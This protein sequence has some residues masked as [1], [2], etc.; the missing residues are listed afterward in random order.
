MNCVPPV[1]G[2]LTALREV[3]TESGA[4]LIFDEVMTGFRVAL[5]GAQAHYDIQPDLTTLGK[6]IGGGMPVG[7]FGGKAEIMQQLAPVG[8]V[9]QAG[10]LSGNPIAMTAGLATLDLISQEGFYSPIFA[11]TAALT[12]GLQKLADQYGIGF[13]SNHVG[14]MFGFFFNDGEKVT[15]YQQV[16]SCNSE[17]FN[18]F[19][20]AMLS[21]GVYLAPASY[22]A[23]FVSACHNTEII[24]QTLAIADKCFAQL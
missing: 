14:T 18:K 2:F 19:F 6:V 9:Y 16:M 20:H 22:E 1:D 12:S 3:C 21:H 4:V 23:G 10:T 5:G 7:A 24:D 17:R 15:G 8:P 13:S 11:A